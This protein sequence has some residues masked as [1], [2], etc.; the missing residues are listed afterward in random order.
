MCCQE[1][2]CSI[3]MRMYEDPVNVHCFKCNEY[4]LITEYKL[5][6]TKYKQI[7]PFPVLLPIFLW[8]YDICQ[9]MKNKMLFLLNVVLT[10]IKAI[11]EY[12]TV[13]KKCFVKQSDCIRL[14]QGKFM[15]SHVNIILKSNEG[16][17]IQQWMGLKMRLYSNSN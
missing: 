14:Y 1:Y 12:K 13:N 7:F 5:R 9:Q 11:T 10:H 6:Y 4:S 16:K 17:Q 3:K 8:H 2:D 15:S